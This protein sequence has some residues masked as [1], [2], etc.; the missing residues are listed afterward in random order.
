[1]PKRSQLNR[2]KTYFG[3][4]FQ[5]LHFMV[6]WLHYLRPE[7]SW[8]EYHGYRNVW[9]RQVLTSWQWWG[10]E[11]REREIEIL[12]RALPPIRPHL[13]Q[14]PPPPNS[15]VIYFILFLWYWDLSSGPIPWATLPALCF[16]CDGFF[17]DRVL[18]SYLP[19]LVLN[20]NPPDLCLPRII[21][22]SHWCPP[23]LNY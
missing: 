21:S 14:F 7:L 9:W 13:L 15:P 4:Q 5:R 22:L 3:S 11:E 19:Q 8:G 6:G 1:M 12:L 16:V 2:E 20:C 23:P 18:R 17:V 10:G